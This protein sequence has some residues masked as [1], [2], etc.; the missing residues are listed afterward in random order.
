[1]FIKETFFSAQMLGF[2]LFYS[3]YCLFI[4][5]CGCAGSSFLLCGLFLRD[6]SRCGARASH[7]C[8]I[9]CQEHRL[10]VCG[11]IQCSSQAPELRFSSCG[12]QAQSLC[13]MWDLPGPDIEPVSPELAG[14]FFSTGPLGKPSV[15]MFN[16]IFFNQPSQKT[17]QLYCVFFPL[18]TTLFSPRRFD[19]PSS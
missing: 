8:G 16:E 12:A 14:R 15:G 11:L 18:F 5:S 17:R 3:L 4:F 13:D 6:C 2:F 1:M 19:E 10:Q 9:S 7:C